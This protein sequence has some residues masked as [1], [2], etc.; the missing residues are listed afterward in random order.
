[1]FRTKAVIFIR[2]GAQR[3][4][5][6]P[7]FSE[8]PHCGIGVSYGTRLPTDYDA[9]FVPEGSGLT[10]DASRPRVNNVLENGGFAIVWMEENQS[11]ANEA[12]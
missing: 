3:S 9:Q 5:P 7:D 1:L 8:K 2:Q 6:V 4:D 11:A 10:S 12:P